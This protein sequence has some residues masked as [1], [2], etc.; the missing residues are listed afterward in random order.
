MAERTDYE[1]VRK[2]HAEMLKKFTYKMG[3]ALKVFQIDPQ[4]LSVRDVAMGLKLIADQ[5]PLIDASEESAEDKAAALEDPLKR[6]RLRV[7]A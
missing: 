2:I 7:V 6:L 5:L 3:E 1:L 4:K